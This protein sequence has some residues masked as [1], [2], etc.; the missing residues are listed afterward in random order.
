MEEI[1]QPIHIMAFVMWLMI[2]ANVGQSLL[3][4]HMRKERMRQLEKRSQQQQ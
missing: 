3:I 2:I 1:F 4:W